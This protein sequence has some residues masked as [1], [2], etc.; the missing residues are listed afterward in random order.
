MADAPI[1]S[2]T[3][4]IH[5]YSVTT[6]PNA[7]V[8]DVTE[9]VSAS[10]YDQQMVKELLIKLLKQDN[11]NQLG[12]LNE[13]LANNGLDTTAEDSNLSKLLNKIKGVIT[14][15]TG[16][17]PGQD[18][19]KMFASQEQR[20][21][22][23]EQ[24]LIAAKQE[25]KTD[26]LKQNYAVSKLFADMKKE[27]QQPVSDLQSA[28]TLGDSAFSYRQLWKDLSD[29]IGSIKSSFVDTITGRLASATGMFQAYN[30]YILAAASKAVT[31]GKDGN[32]VEF[33]ASLIAKARNDFKA[34]LK[35]IDLGSVA[36]WDNL[37]PDEK[38]TA[39]STYNPLI[40]IDAHGK[41]SFDVSLLDALPNGPAGASGNSVSN[42]SYQA[43]VVQLNG[44]TSGMQS[45]LQSLA[46]RSSQSNTTFDNLVKLLSSS[47]SSL[48][49]LVKSVFRA[50]A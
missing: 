8:Q 22:R 26:S 39:A 50:I 3:N 27:A 45:G 37:S 14:D 5:L 9:S 41:L 42:A 30:K 18:L 47:I 12:E 33:D 43:W 16:A 28:N 46:Q 19:E 10:P 4:L 21:K 2:L 44:V 48:A 35:T 38:K 20:V 40:K 17:Q 13:L 31:A 15:K 24:L 36:N 49:D 34:V 1:Q 11:S 29:A 23:L 25:I 32:T 7:P 6:P